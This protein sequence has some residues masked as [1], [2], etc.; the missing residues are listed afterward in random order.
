MRGSLCRIGWS[1]SGSPNLPRVKLLEAQLET[2]SLKILSLK[3]R[4]VIERERDKRF[5][6]KR[7][8]KREIEKI[9]SL[10]RERVYATMREKR[11]ENIF[12]LNS[13]V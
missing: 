5:S 8:M 13:H 7:R 11:R 4:T 3:K 1:S 10:K 12:I 9:L 6:L 2:L